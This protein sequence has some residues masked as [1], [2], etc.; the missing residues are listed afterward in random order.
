M[1]ETG[2]KE[3]E[4]WPLKSVEIIKSVKTRRFFVKLLLKRY[5]FRSNIFFYAFFA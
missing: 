1:I 2:R 3:S 4:L 5:I